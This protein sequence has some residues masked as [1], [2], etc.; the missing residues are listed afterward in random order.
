MNICETVTYAQAFYDNKIRIIG[1]KKV[2]KILFAD[3]AN[4]YR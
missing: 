4:I 3:C 2:L 1:K